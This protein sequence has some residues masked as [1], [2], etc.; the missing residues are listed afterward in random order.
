MFRWINFH[1]NENTTFNNNQQVALLK[2]S[3]NIGN[4]G[5]PIQ[6]LGL[7]KAVK[8]PNAQEPNQIP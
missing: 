7:I 8:V 6:Q 2:Y 4:N 5:E 3:I 1:K